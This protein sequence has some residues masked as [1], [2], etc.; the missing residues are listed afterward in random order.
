MTSDI[1]LQIWTRKLEELSS[2]STVLTEK[3]SINLLP[4]SLVL[5][6]LQTLPTLRSS[7]VPEDRAEV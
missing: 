6:T 3:P 1:P 7:D 4:C 5:E 2:A